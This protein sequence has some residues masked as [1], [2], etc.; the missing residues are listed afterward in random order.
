M[1]DFQTMA[2]NVG[3]DIQDTSSAMAVIIKRYINKRYLDILRVVNIQPIN[4][5]YVISLASSM[6]TLPADF[7]K[8]LYCVDSTN[9]TPL[10]RIDYEEITRIDPTVDNDPCEP[11]SYTIFTDQNGAKQVRVWDNSD[12]A[13]VLKLPYMVKPAPLS[14]TSDAPLIPCE[15]AIEAGAQADAW[16]YKRQ[17]AKAQAFEAIYADLVSNLMWDTE[18]QPSYPRQFT[19]TTYNRD[20][21]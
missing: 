10:K 8:E 7:G 6:A 2:E 1:R 9:N 15:D 21:L 3:T 16:R 14:A 12:K 13:I 11:D 18:N 5:T 17:F 4:S 20:L 19:P